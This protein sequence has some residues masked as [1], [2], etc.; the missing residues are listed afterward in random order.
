MLNQDTP[1]KNTLM[2][3]PK[4]ALAAMDETVLPLVLCAMS[5]AR[6]DLIDRIV[7]KA[8]RDAIAESDL[9]PLAPGTVRD[10]EYEKGSPMTF[11]AD[12]E[13]RPEVTLEEVEGFEVRNTVD[14]AFSGTSSRYLAAVR[15]CWIHDVGGKGISHVGASAVVERNIVERTW[16]TGIHCNAAATV[17]NNLVVSA[18][19]DAGKVSPHTLRHAFASH[20]LANGAD[21]RA[22]QQM[23][24]HADI[25]TTQIYTHVLR[26]RLQEFVEEHHPLAD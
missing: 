16:D 20:L 12:L 18:G 21:L 2:A 5:G 9:D 3:Q 11:Y 7:P 17:R 8:Y 1:L 26:Q 10:F 22:V 15:D 23:L 13:V 4:Q 14:D 25:S 6:A 24:G 19:I